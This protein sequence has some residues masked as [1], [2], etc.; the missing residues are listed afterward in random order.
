MTKAKTRLTSANP[1]KIAK[2]VPNN[3][4]IG[5]CRVS[6]REQ[7]DDGVSL[8]AQKSRITEFAS[9]KDLVL[10]NILSEDGVSGSVPLKDRPQGSLIFKY[11]KENNV[12]LV[13]ATKLDRLFRDALDCL[14]MVKEWEKH[15]VRVLL[16][17]MGVDFST[18]TGKAFLTNAASF[19][20]LERNL[21]SERTKDGLEQVKKEGVRLGGESW[22]WKRVDS[23]DEK[24]RF[25]QVI[26]QEELEVIIQIKALRESGHTF[27]SIC[28]TLLAEGVKTKKGGKW[29]PMT[30]KKICEMDI[31]AIDHLEIEES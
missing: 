16:L 18:P 21:I 11:I 22:G 1:K 5:Y 13:V 24:G 12:R 31:S 4:A 6:T 25:K 19:A 10:Y 2:N 17:D 9:S 8:D 26:V 15:G 7:A 28:D 20:E 14:A 27:Q 3:I 23:M 30:V 29:W